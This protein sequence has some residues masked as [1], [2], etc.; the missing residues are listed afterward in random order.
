MIQRARVCQACCMARLWNQA[1]WPPTSTR[2]PALVQIHLKWGNVKTIHGSKANPPRHGVRYI[3]SS[4]YDYYTAL[5]CVIIC[6]SGR[7]NIY[8]RGGD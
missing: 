5:D 1:E 6:Q 4:R 3:T 7:N 8:A 2:R